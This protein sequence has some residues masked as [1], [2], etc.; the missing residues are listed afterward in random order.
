MLMLYIDI[1][2]NKC[3]QGACGVLNRVHHG[4]TISTTNK[5]EVIINV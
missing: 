4:D 3:Y 5:P 2:K 1:P